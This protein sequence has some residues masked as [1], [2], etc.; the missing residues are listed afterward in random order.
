[1]SSRV[2][3]LWDVNQTDAKYIGKYEGIFKVVRYLLGKK[4]FAH[5][6]LVKSERSAIAEMASGILEDMN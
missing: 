2:F 1:M 6:S 4:L 5:V 3:L